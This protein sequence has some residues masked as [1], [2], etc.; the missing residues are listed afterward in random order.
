MRPG[1]ANLAS[2]LSSMP[3]SSSPRAPA[4]LSANAGPNISPSFLL[5]L[6]Y[7]SKSTNSF[8]DPRPANSSCSSSTLRWSPISSS[9]SAAPA[10]APMADSV[11]PPRDPSSPASRGFFLCFCG[12]PST[13]PASRHLS[14]VRIGREDNRPDDHNRVHRRTSSRLIRSIPF[15]RL[16]IPLACQPEEDNSLTAAPRRL[17]IQPQHIPRRIPET[18]RNLRG[19]RSDRLRNLSPVRHRL[20]KRRRNA[21]HHDIHRQPHFSHR[22]PSKHPRPAHL[23]RRIVKRHTPIAPS[24]DVPSKHRPI[25][26]FRACDI[27]ARHLDIAA[28]LRRLRSPS[29]SSLVLPASNLLSSPWRSNHAKPKSS[30]FSSPFNSGRRRWLGAKPGRQSKEV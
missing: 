9:N 19:I 25:E 30:W 16:R 4:S 1:S 2:A 21:I 15:G 12:L 24:S 14:S 29:A 17:L 10:S 27:L 23:P 3:R 22:R 18:R 13:R 7:R 26:R 11:T 5:L 20:L 8:T 6:S 28:G